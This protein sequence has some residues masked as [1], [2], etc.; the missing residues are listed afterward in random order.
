MTMVELLV[1]SIPG[2]TYNYGGLSPDNTAAT[3]NKAM[4]ANPRQAALQGLDLMRSVSKLGVPQVVLP[5]HERPDIPL[6]R[7]LGFGGR[8]REVVG[9][10][11]KQGLL[12]P[13]C[14]SSAVWTANLATISPST[15]RK[16][17]LTPANL[18]THF[19]RSTETAFTSKL[20]KLVFP[21]DAFVHHAALPPHVRFGD[22]GAANHMRLSIGPDTSGQ[23]LFAYGYED[24]RRQVGRQSLRASQAIARLHQL[25]PEN[26]LFA[27]QHPHAIRAGAFH[28]DVLGVSNNN[29]MLIHGS[30]FVR[31]SQIISELSRRM[32][33]HLR[34]REVAESEMSLADAVRSYFFN[35]QI[36]SLPHGG[37]VMLAPSECEAIPSAKRLLDSLPQSDGPIT[38]VQTFDLHESMNNG[39]GPACL[40]LRVLLNE[41]E[42][43]HVNPACILT[44]HLYSR[45]V[46]S[47]NK[48][49]PESLGPEELADPS[50]LQQAQR[51]LDELAQI[52]DIGCPYS[53][54]N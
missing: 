9:A 38:E 31:Q 50:L 30:A 46:E 20:L 36:I 22:E 27:R 19:H 24:G 42:L 13:C 26:V 5:P 54:Q 49:Y 41:Q 34:I 25:A 18:S 7:Q 12:G 48:N 29:F 35:S 16:V 33:G 23:H 52:L 32:Q 40:R 3:G 14:S 8:D 47:V 10:A 6:L 1:G 44:E 43:A 37:A 45:L 28:T 53:F 15:D 17:H 2:P 11:A 4:P 21:G 51:S 39:G